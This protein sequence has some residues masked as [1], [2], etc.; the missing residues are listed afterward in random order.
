MRSLPSTAIFVAV[1]TLVWSQ[2]WAEGPPK[3]KMTTDVPEGIGTPDRVNTQI[4]TAYARQRG[5]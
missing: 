5:A 2:A 1:A 3:M 4:G